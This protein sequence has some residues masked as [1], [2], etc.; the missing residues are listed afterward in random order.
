[1]NRLEY[2]N[3]LLDVATSE[4]DG[5]TIDRLGDLRQVAPGL[6]N[7]TGSATDSPFGEH[8]PV[9][10]LDFPCRLVRSR[11]AGHYHLY[12]DKA[13]PFDLM[14]DALEAMCRAGWVQQGFVDGARRRGA[15]MVRVE[16][17]FRPHSQEQPST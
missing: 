8:L 17:T 13:T 3:D 5:A 12:I 1:M 11:T 15:A 4:N 6:G 2:R 10:D 16:G 14:I 9:V 7:L